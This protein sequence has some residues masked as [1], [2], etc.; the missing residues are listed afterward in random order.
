VRQ[1]GDVVDCANE[2][3]MSRIYGGIH[4]PSANRDGKAT[5]TKIAQFVYQNFLLPNAELPRL[6]IDLDGTGKT[7]LRAQGH[8]GRPCVLESTFDLNQWQPVATNI[9]AVG[10]SIIPV[11]NAASQSQF[12][13]I[14]EQ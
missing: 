8:I 5:G 14:R 13:R 2:I 12:F 11:D 10:G 9:L 3:G 1:Y 7:T 6:G 4:F